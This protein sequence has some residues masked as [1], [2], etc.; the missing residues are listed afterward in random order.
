[1]RAEYLTTVAQ[2]TAAATP[3][4][5]AR[6]LLAED[7]ADGMTDH[8]H[9]QVTAVAAGLIVGFYSLLAAAVWV[10]VRALSWAVR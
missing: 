9:R 5:P 7:P 10:A 2:L 6:A 8:E 3:P 1:M 4:K